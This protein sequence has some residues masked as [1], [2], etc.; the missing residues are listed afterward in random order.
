LFDLASLASPDELRC[1]IEEAQVL[2]VFKLPAIEELINR[3]RGH[4]GVARLRQ[5]VE[6]LDPQT[7]HTRSSLERRF[8]ALCRRAK[9][10]N[11][12]V[13]VPMRLEG[14]AFE[15]DFVWRDA[16]V[17]VETDGRQF[18]DTASAFE[19]DRVRDQH[20]I[21]AGWRVLRCT[22]RQVVQEPLEL[23][24]TLRTVLGQSRGRRDL[25]DP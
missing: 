17:I 10:P 7:I 15:A 24:E 12:D 9:L 25:A 6:D 23:A 5:G 20:L 19:R 18:H 1:A 14:H 4:G 21:L 16:G 8:L 2:R 3:N 11:P 13:N 22:W